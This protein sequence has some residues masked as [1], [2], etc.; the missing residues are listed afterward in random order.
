LYTVHCTLFSFTFNR[1][2]SKERNEL[3]Q[4]VKSVEVVAKAAENGEAK[5]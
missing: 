1:V 2:L 4:K 3:L 5:A